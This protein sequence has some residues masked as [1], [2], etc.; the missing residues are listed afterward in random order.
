VADDAELARAMRDIQRPE[1]LATL[2]RQVQVARRMFAPERLAA[3]YLI[4]L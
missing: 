4:G 1:T 2:K 3:R